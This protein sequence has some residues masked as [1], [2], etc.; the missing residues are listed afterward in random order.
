ML[1]RFL[2]DLTLRF[3]F[4]YNIEGI[5]SKMMIANR[6]VALNERASADCYCGRKI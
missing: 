1:L 2:N 6:L 4:F 5:P 3:V